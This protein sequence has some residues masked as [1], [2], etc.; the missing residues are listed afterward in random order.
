MSILADINSDIV[1]LLKT[2]SVF[3][4]VDN[5]RSQWDNPGENQVPNTPACYVKLDVDSIEQFPNA[6]NL[7]NLNVI[8]TT[9]DKKY[10]NSPF[11]DQ[12]ELV[13]EV[14]NLLSSQ[15]FDNKTSNLYRT[16]IDMDYNPNNYIVNMTSFKCIVFDDQVPIINRYTPVSSATFSVKTSYGGTGSNIK[17][18]IIK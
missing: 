4:W 9:V 3:K 7:I 10:Y 18:D 16:D 13:A 6:R 11:Y 14:Y 5:D 1:N 17:N 15:T 8:I 12:W 2:S